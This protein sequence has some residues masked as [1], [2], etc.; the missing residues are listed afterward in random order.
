MDTPDI[1]LQH[2]KLTKKLQRDN[3]KIKY[4]TFLEQFHINAC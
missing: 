3:N 4:E 1:N 2:I